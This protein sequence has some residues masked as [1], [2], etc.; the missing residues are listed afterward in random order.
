VTTFA[1][2]KIEIANLQGALAGVMLNMPYL[3]L[4]APR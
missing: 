3:P 4:A 2:A 1:I